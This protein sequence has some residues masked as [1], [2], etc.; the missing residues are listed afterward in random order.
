MLINGKMSYNELE[1]LV[2]FLKKNVVN[3]YL[4]KL[5]HYEGLWLFKFNH[6][7][8]VFEPGNAIWIGDFAERETILHSICIKIRKEIGDHKIIGIDLIDNDRTVI[9]QF[10]NHKI[11]LELYAKGN[12]ILVDNENKIMVLTRIYPDCSHGK[13]YTIKDYK[14]YSDF[15][16]DKFGWAVKNYEIS[17]KFESFNDIWEAMSELWKVKYS[18]KTDKKEKKIEKKTKKKYSI[19]DNI[20]NQINGFS[21]KINKKF[22]TIEKLESVNYESIDYKELGKIH[23]ERKKIQSKLDKAQLALSEVETKPIKKKEVIQK[24]KINSSLWYHKYHWWYT[25]NNFLVVG[26][27]NSTDNEKLVKSYLND[28]DLYF[29]S[30]DPGSGSFIMFTENRTPDFVDIDETAE[31]VL[32]FSNQWNSSYSAG[33][34]FYV[35][36]NQVSKTPP[37]GEFISKGSFMI[38]GKKD[39]VKVS[40]CTLGYGLFNENQLMLGPFRTI[41]RLN[42]N[43]VKLKPRSDLKKM[44]GKLISNA[45]K[46]TLNIELDDNLYIFNKPCNI[47][48]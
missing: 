31:G 21:N 5:Y 45:L 24:I 27:K 18:L 9:I 8:F 14:N 17:N 30:E 37:T 34:V 19:E 36:G 13:T 39:F 44:K 15:K 26:G 11:I 3:S 38:Y 10:H 6:C 22:N 25:K 43:N 41:S 46:K 1:Q 12:L 20:Q 33:D 42:G 7:Q 48:C 16:I 40:S 23:G 32:A 4:K 47:F 2:F 35:K 28:N 29:H